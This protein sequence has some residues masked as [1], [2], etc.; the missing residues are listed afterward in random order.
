ME[1]LENTTDLYPFNPIR[2]ETVLSRFPVHRLAK[3]GRIEIEISEADEG[4]EV[5]T[6][7]EVTYNSKYGQPGALAYKVDTLLVNRRIDEAPRPVPEILRLGSLKE[8]GEELGLVD[9][10]KNRNDIKRALNQNAGA[11]INAKKNYKGADGVER[12]LEI[13]DTRYGVIF[14]GK[15]FPDGTRADAVYLILHAA[16]REIINSAPLRPLDY[17]YLLDLAPGPQRL[18]ELLSFQIFAALKNGRP[19]AR[20]LYSY[21]CTRAPVTR[22]FDHEHVKKQMYKLNAPH[23]LSGYVDDVELREFRGADGRP[24]WEMLYTPGRRAKAEFRELKRARRSLEASLP[25]EPVG[26]GRPALPPPAEAVTSNPELESLVAELVG[27]KVS[28]KKARELAVTKPEAVRLQLRAL[29]FLP[30]GQGRKNYA[31]RLVAAVENDYALPRPLLEL[32][33][34]ERHDKT[35]RAAA[36][37]AEGC[38]YCREFNG[39]WYPKGFGGPVRR[40]THDPAKEERYRKG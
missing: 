37:R 14:T 25:E 36:S 15:R 19:R 2:V 13:F 24:D 40:C 7:W 23:R 8:L 17:A 4:G 34:K 20:M 5:K 27:H 18:Y 6:S 28:E 10:G 16:F 22:Y 30:E 32:I 12:T 11:T 3:K 38:S 33:E 9:S 26:S 35:L 21:F 1:T 39:V 31:G 29:P